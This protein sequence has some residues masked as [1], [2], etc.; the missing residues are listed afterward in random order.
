VARVAVLFL[1]GVCAAV[2]IH[3]LRAYD[4]CDDARAAARVAGL[5]T[6]AGA[7]RA[8]A[9]GCRDPRDEAFSAA[10]LAAHGNR[11]VAAELARRMIRQSPR[12]YLGWVAVG[13]LTGSRAALARAHAL[14]PRGVPRP[15]RP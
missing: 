8:V 7:A 5:T 3:G 10:E 14:K 6:A 2:G 4:R 11:A 9:A 1:A 12:D 13:R 15:P